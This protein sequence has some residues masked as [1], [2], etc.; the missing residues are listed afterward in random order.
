[1]INLREDHRETTVSG[2]LSRNG[3]VLSRCG[4]HHDMKVIKF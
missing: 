4:K 2:G 1:M 3:P